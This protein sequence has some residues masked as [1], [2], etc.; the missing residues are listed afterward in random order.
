MICADSFR[1]GASD[2][3]GSSTILRLSIENIPIID[4]FG[5]PP[6]RCLLLSRVQLLLKERSLL[7]MLIGCGLMAWLR[8]G[9]LAGRLCLTAATVL[10][11]VFMAVF[12]QIY[13]TGAD[14]RADHA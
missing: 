1:T 6:S 9:T 5:D 12:G 2:G 7:G 8:H 4:F 14:G 11:G 13:Q 10:V 3:S